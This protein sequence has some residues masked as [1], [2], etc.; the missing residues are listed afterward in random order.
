MKNFT[1][2]VFFL[3]LFLN[4]LKFH[5]TYLIRQLRLM[6]LFGRTFIYLLY[7]GEK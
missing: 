1:L 7:T 2:L 3:L 5:V 4:I 6:I